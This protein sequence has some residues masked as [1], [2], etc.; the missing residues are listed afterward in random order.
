MPQAVG[1]DTRRA[2]RAATDRR[3]V[4]RNLRLDRRHVDLE[5][6]GSL[7]RELDGTVAART[8]LG[9]GMHLLVVDMRG[10]RTVRRGMSG[11]ASGLLPRPMLAPLPARCPPL[12]PLAKATL[13]LFELATEL[14]QLQSQG[15]I[16]LLKLLDPF[17][18]RHARLNDRSRNEWTAP[19]RLPSK[20]DLTQ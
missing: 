17:R 6:A 5:R 15:S 19:S 12:A 4:T 9:R 14:L 13:P 10:N 11:F 7:L 18:G 16:L 8:P 3:R 2:S 1:H 20:I